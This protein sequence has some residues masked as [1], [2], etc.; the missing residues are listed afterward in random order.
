MHCLE[1]SYPL[2]TGMTCSECGADNTRH[3]HIFDIETR[4]PG[5]FRRMRRGFR[6]VLIYAILLLVTAGLLQILSLI[7][8]RFMTPNAMGSTVNAF[9]RVSVFI[10]IAF[11]ALMLLAALWFAARHAKAGHLPPN[12]VAASRVLFLGSLLI[13]LLPLTMKLLLLFHWPGDVERF[14]SRFFEFIGRNWWLDRLGSY[15]FVIGQLIFVYLC[16]QSAKILRAETARGWFRVGFFFLIASV[17]LQIPDLFIVIATE[18]GFVDYLL[19]NAINPPGYILALGCIGQVRYM[20]DLATA[21]FLLMGSIR[22]IQHLR[23]LIPKETPLHQN[24]GA[25]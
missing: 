18:L 10:D 21:V 17:I 22:F 2:Q 20:V 1:C 5:S 12:L 7:A 16:V 15:A 19:V 14:L 23:L 13:T 24:G 8:P 11:P 9:F 4:L 3:A 25:A 6:C